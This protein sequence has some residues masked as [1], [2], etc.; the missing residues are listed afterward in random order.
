M[1]LATARWF[2]ARW[3]L[4]MTSMHR[5]LRRAS[6]QHWVLS[7]DQALADGMT[8][9][10]I[11][12]VLRNR[13]WRRV[14]PSVYLV[15]Q[16]PITWKARLMAA[17]LW[18]GPGAVASHRS[19]AALLALRHGDKDRLEISSP[20][21]LNSRYGITIHHDS[22]L[23]IKAI[24]YSDNIPVTRMARTILDLCAVL[25]Y[26][27]ATSAVVDAVRRDLLSLLDLCRVLDEPSGKRGGRTVLRRIL[28]TRFAR[29]VT[30]SDAEDL[31]IE[32]AEHRGLAFVHHFVVQDPGFRAELDFAEVPIRL[33]VEIDGGKGHNDP[34]AVQRD[35]NRDAE[36]ISRGWTVL[37]FTYWDLIR[38]PDWVF[39]TIRVVQARREASV[40]TGPPNAAGL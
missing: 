18:A 19:A 15:G 27:A 21:R 7:R 39:E 30:D 33:D 8:R 35:K 11:S 3:N 23:P 4:H 1:A 20:R 29:G 26:S 37:R 16:A 17:I 38:R 10:S 28:M 6:R 25:S 13:E 12:R 14:F 24:A 36:L 2:K 22:S 40:T 31:F 32:M 5:A 9:H 34:V